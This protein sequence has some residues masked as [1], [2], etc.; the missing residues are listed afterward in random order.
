MKECNMCQKGICIFEDNWNGLCAYMPKEFLA[1]ERKIYSNLCYKLNNQ[2]RVVRPQLNV[3]SRT[4]EI[5]RDYRKETLMA[6]AGITGYEDP[7]VDEV[8]GF[9]VRK[10]L[11]EFEKTYSPQQCKAGAHTG[12]KEKDK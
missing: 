10:K 5:T 3:D 8:S 6:E 9:L 12:I 4:G 2:L 7:E 11:L 1:E